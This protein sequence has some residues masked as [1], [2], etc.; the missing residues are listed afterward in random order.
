MAFTLSPAVPSDAEVLVRNCEFPAMADN[1]LRLLMFPNPSPKTSEEE[2]V[3]MIDNLRNSL[4]RDHGMKFWKVCMADGMPVG[5]AGWTAPVL[6]EANSKKNG[7]VEEDI[8]SPAH[9]STEETGLQIQGDRSRVIT[10]EHGDGDAKKRPL[11]GSLDIEMWFSISR[12]FAVEKERVLQGRKD[13]WRKLS[14][15]LC[16]TEI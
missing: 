8:T 12:K 3:W 9:P 11:P 1:P 2:I 7:A 15:T 4:T 14:P 6:D 13:I 16:R 10:N 5:F